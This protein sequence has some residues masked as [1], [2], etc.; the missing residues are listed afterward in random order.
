[1]K[2]NFTH[3]SVSSSD[4]DFDVFGLVHLECLTRPRPTK[5]ARKRHVSEGGLGQRTQKG[6]G[7]EKKKSNEW[8]NSKI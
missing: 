5:S 2:R 7:R 6:Q 8:F 4:A 1:M 3:L